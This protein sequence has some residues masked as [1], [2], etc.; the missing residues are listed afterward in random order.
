MRESCP[1]C[2]SRAIYVGVREVECGTPGCPNHRT[3]SSD[4]PRSE[5]HAGGGAD[6]HEELAA[7]L[8]EHAE[9]GFGFF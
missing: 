1:R 8:Y 7:L 4:A 5:R 2:G 6:D 3:T 9:Q